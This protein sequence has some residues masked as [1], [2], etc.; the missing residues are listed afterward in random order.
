MGPGMGMSFGVCSQCGYSHPPIPEGSK[1]PMA[2]EKSPS[3]KVIEY[4]QFFSSLKNILTSQIQKK[5]IKD[6]N[7]FLGNIIIEIV[8]I[9][10]EYKET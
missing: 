6:T 9:A 7:K 3:G 2:K 8:K 5:N 4:E 10:G 1:C